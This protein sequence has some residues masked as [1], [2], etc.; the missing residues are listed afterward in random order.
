MACTHTWVRTLGSCTM[1]ALVNSCY[2]PAPYQFPDGVPFMHPSA[3]LHRCAM[4]DGW[5]GGDKVLKAAGNVRVTEFLCTIVTRT[6]H[7][8][9]SSA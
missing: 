1:D 4:Y 5:S 3:T 6:P 9:L 8:Y 2:L 7:L